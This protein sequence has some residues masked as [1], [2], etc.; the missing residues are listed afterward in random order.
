MGTVYRAYDPLMDREVAIKVIHDKSLQVEETHARFVREARTAGKLS[1]ANITVVHDFGEVDGRTF[2][3][4]EYLD[5]TDLRAIIDNREPLTLREKI[6][7]A[8]QICR[9]LH[10]AHANLIIHRD[11]KPENIKV[12]RDGRVK[13]MDFGI[14]KPYA[15]TRDADSFE[16]NEVLTRMGMRIGTPWYMSPEQVKGV[17]VDK[18]SDI[19]S[20]GVLLYELLTYVRPFDGDDTTVLYKILHV[21]PEP[22]RLDDKGLTAGCQKILSRCLAKNLDERYADCL[23]VLRDLEAIPRANEETIVVQELI[24]EG[25]KL[26]AEKRSAE[27]T[28]IFEEAL[29]RDPENDEAASSLLHLT[30]VNDDSVFVRVLTGKIVGEVLSHFQIIER[31]GSGGMGVVYKAED[32]TLKRIVALKFLPPDR[33][34]DQ[35]GKKRFLKEAQAASGLDHPN[36]CPVHEISETLEGLVF[37]CMAYY[38]G[39]DL[40]T[41]IKDNPLDP[42]TALTIAIG[43]ARGLGAAHANGIIHRDIKPGNIII[44]RD[45]VPKIVDFG[46]AKLTGGTKLTRVG[47]ALGTLPY[48]SPEQITSRTQDHRT[49]IWSLGV[50]VYQTLTGQLPFEG[51]YEAAIAHSILNEPPVPLRQRH[52]ELPAVLDSIINGT[53]AKEPEKRYASMEALVVD[54]ERAYRAIAPPRPTDLTRSTECARL[55]ETGEF[56]MERREFAEALSRFEAAL[57]LSPGDRRIIGLRDECYQKMGA[58]GR[59]ARALAE[60]RDLLEKGNLREAEEKVLGILAASPGHPGATQLAED[61]RVRLERLEGVEKLVS[62]GE[63]Y[64]RRGKSEEAEACFKRALETDPANKTALRALKRLE[65]ERLLISRKRKSATPVPGLPAARP[66]MIW[67]GA[68]GGLLVVAALVVWLTVRPVSPSGP[69]PASAVTFDSTGIVTPVREQMI[70]MKEDA[71]RVNATR[72]APEIADSAVK[73]EMRG[74]R[75][76]LEHRFASSFA[77]FVSAR[78]YY[79]RARDEAQKNEAAHTENLTDLQALVSRTRDEMRKARSSAETA[80]GRKLVPALFLEAVAEENAGEKKAAGGTRDGLLAARDSFASARDRYAGLRLEAERLTGLKNEADASHGDL[81]AAKR[82]VAGTEQEKSGNNNYR[83]AVALESQADRLYRAGDFQGARDWYAQAQKLYAGARQEILPVRTPVE[84]PA[85]KGTSPV[86]AS[87]ASRVP[88]EDPAKKERDFRDAADKAFHGLLDTYKDAIE[89]GDAQKLA[90]LLRLNDDAAG[91]W[92]GFFGDSNDRHVT[93]RGVE[94]D[95]TDQTARL[96]FRMNLSFFNKIENS[97]QNQD[98]LRTWTLE[99]DATG[100]RILTQK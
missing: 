71:A 77:E 66:R 39:E 75:A 63:F 38:P 85:D 35:T 59:I 44:T 19:F 68:T 51:E 3:V 81:V 1:H 89:R 60:A 42:A 88:A 95:I 49:D 36:I 72:W 50:L 45:G 32:I 53:L 25:K 37:I 41:K 46:L 55:V 34:Q 99:R 76:L 58:E 69:P 21:E 48:M 15:P 17:P 33:T 91:V 47:A 79:D 62:D 73:A 4:M 92:N 57:R 10:Y 90:G 18:R 13:I 70:S 31:I 40:R 28:R 6:G 27:A 29:A 64:L 100:W 11:I 87:D 24:K 43:I 86:P 97:T 94:F 30:G 74:E 93:I 23:H 67:I 52:S 8:A 56:L 7:Y 98:F 14:A 82:S 16:T 2:I 78:D 54:L 26:A 61:V 80:K 96:R 5:G 9:G 20:F 83:S 65:K 22:V 12:L 84:H